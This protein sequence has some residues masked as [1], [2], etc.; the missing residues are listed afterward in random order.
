MNMI[1]KIL[2]L[3]L[4]IC[5]LAYG[6]LCIANSSACSG[7]GTGDGAPSVADRNISRVAYVQTPSRGYYA[8]EVEETAGFVTLYNYWDRQGGKWRYNEGETLPLERKYIGKISVIWIEG[9]Q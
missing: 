8:L 1:I 5:S 2:V 9:D 7:P 3:C 4:M 6:Y